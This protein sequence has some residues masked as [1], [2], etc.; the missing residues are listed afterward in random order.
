[1]GT[2]EDEEL[3]QEFDGRFHWRRQRQIDNLRRLREIAHWG[4]PDS[5]SAL[6]NLRPYGVQA[7]SGSGDILY[8]LRDSIVTLWLEATECFIF[9]QFQACILTCGAVV[10]RCLKVE[11]QKV[12]GQLP[13]G[14][15]P[16][17]RCI[18]ELDWNGILDSEVLEL[19]MQLLEPRNSRAHALL[20][21]S[22]PNAAT[23]GGNRDVQILDSQRYLIEP[24]RGDAED[25]ISVTWKILERL[26]GGTN[27]SDTI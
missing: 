23:Y 21:H 9:G 4:G 7:L 18:Y 6:I 13:K 24:Y 25:V 16:L 8:A 20:E 19:S 2:S 11:Y 5:L 26:Y 15:W 12:H 10:E 3:V 17:G 27:T 14:N 1:M 22:D